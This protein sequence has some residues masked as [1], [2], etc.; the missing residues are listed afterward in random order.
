[1]KIVTYICESVRSKMNNTNMTPMAI[2]LLLLLISSIYVGMGVSS[3]DV[4]T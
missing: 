2:L 3:S 1:M 4:C